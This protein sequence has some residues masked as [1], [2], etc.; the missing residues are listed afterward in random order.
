MEFSPC[1]LCWSFSLKCDKSQGGAWEAFGG[2]DPGLQERVSQ[3]QDCGVLRCQGSCVKMNV[4][5][6]ADVLTEELHQEMQS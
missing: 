4:G 2:G 1:L 3:P 5:V 6:V